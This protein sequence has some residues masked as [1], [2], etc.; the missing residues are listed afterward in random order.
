MLWIH[1]AEMAES[2]TPNKVYKERWLSLGKAWVSSGL[3]GKQGYGHGG[4]PH[5]QKDT[6]HGSQQLK[7]RLS[8][9]NGKNK[10]KNKRAKIKEMR[11]DC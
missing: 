7:H 6:K 10:D 2:P 3:S 1:S 4:S 11:W 8:N 5:T 9:N